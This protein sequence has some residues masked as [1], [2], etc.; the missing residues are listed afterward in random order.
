MAFTEKELTFINDLLIKIHTIDDIKIMREQVLLMMQLLIPCEKSSFFLKGVNEEHML[1]D[2]VGVGFSDEILSNYINEY[3][4]KDIFRWVIS[5]SESRVYRRTDFF[6]D[7]AMES[8]PFY[9]AYWKSL[10]LYYL[11]F[12]GLCYKDDFLGIISFY[13][14]KEAG[15]FTDEEAFILDLI[16]DHLNVK[17]FDSYSGNTNAIQ[18]G[19]FDE[20]RFEELSQTYNLTKRELDI[21]ELWCNGFTDQEITNNLMITKNTLKKHVTNIYRK[22]NIGNKIELLKLLK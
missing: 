5:Y 7:S 21:L 15:D 17:L 10:D 1:A 19:H 13:R 8:I 22:L 2:P 3:A 11:L 20:C 9:K 4:E 14:K 16:K 12:A 18:L 6:S